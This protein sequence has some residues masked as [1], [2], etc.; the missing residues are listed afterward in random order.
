[1]YVSVT[2]VQKKKCQK[3]VKIT[4]DSVTNS[5]SGHAKNN[6]TWTNS[7]LCTNNSGQ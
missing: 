6:V 1:M 4:Q 5:E 2:L 7:V 3:R